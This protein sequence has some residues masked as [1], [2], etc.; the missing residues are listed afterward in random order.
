MLQKKKKKIQKFFF[1]LFTPMTG[2]FFSR[3]VE[4]IPMIDMIKV[5]PEDNKTENVMKSKV[6]SI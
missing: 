3:K 1:E 2:S 6:K 5:D 4:M